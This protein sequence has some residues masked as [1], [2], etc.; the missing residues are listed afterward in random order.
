MWGQT[1]P[2]IEHQETAV[3]GF[4]RNVKIQCSITADYEQES[5]TISGFD[6]FWIINGSV[7]GLLQVPR[8]FVVCSSENIN[9]LEIPNI[10]SEMDG[11]T[12][13][14]VS[15]D[16]HRNTQY[17]GGVTAL[18]VITPQNGTFVNLING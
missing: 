6:V 12:F 3:A 5:V 16:H 10:E 15:I 18:T 17:L 1:T 13:Q 9:C 8:D 11:Y 7:Y 14:C 2:K 4:S